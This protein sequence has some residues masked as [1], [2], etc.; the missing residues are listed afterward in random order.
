[1]PEE[2]ELFPIRTVATLTGMNPVT[3]R[4]W[5]RRYGLIKPIRTPSGHRLYTR[6][7]IDQVH[8]V[9]ALLEKGMAIGQVSRSLRS[10]AAQAEDSWSL[11]RRRMLAAIGRFDEPALEELYNEALAAHPL[12]LVTRR[13]LLPLLAELGAR[14]EAAEGTVAE[15]HFFSLYVRNKI[16]ARFHHRTQA[17]SGARLLGACAPGEH[18]ELGLM[19]FALAAHEAGLR[20]VLLGANTPLSDLPAAC[21]VAHCDAIVLSSSIAPPESFAREQLPALVARAEKPVFVG[22]ATSV[23][24][25]DD[26]VAAGATCLGTDVAL[27][28]RR[29]IESLNPGTEAG[30]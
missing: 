27:G 29:L 4:A 21:R 6:E 23:S 11:L 3:L 26:I 12:E 17:V 24:H 9:L 30:R 19:L 2:Q 5:E 14:W 18:H 20:A 1:M 7:H 13:L 28:V 10:D 16:G 15:E 22:G 8:R 25:R